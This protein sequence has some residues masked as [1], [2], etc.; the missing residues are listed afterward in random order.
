MAENRFGAILFACILTV[1]LCHLNRGFAMTAKH[2]FYES[3]LHR[4]S[5]SLEFLAPSVALARIPLLA[6]GLMLTIGCT[7]SADNTVEATLEIDF[8]LQV[9]QSARVSSENIAVGFTAVTSDSRCGK[10]EV[11]IWEGDATVRIWL[12]VNGGEKEERELHTA[13][14]E[15]SAASFGGY[16]IRL[17]AL[18]PPPISGRAI[19]P[20]EYV[21]N[22]RL[23][24]GSSGEQGVY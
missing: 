13:S 19:G 24:R 20:N 2:D 21:A 18:F 7:A 3:L 14:R 16:S 10:G 22:L 4:L 11:C 8:Q 9:G 6:T 12:Q 17:V 23:I 1:T 15:P 5:T